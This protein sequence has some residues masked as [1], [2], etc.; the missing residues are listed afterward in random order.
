MLQI[1]NEKR[2]KKE[3]EPDAIHQGTH[4]NLTHVCSEHPELPENSE[5]VMYL[6]HPLGP[7]SLCP[8]RHSAT[9]YTSY[10][11]GNINITV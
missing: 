2:K 11:F 5:V 10:D 8:H 9:L 4:E 3:P 7:H 1:R 6:S